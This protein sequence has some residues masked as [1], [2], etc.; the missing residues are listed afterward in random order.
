MK[1]I[2]I[3]DMSLTLGKADILKNITLCMEAGNI[4]GLVGRNGSGKTMLMKCI[5]GFLR[6]TQGRIMIDD[7]Q[8]G[9][10]IDFPPSLGCVIEVPGFIP[11]ESGIKNLLQLAGLRRQIDKAKVEAAMELVGLE[12]KKQLPVGKYSL[13]MRQRLGLAQALMEEPELL[14]LDEPFNSLDEYGLQEMRAVIKNYA[15]N[16]RIVIMASHS[17]EDIGILC[18][19]VFYLRNGRCVSAHVHKS[20]NMK[21]DAQEGLE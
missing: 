6:P 10:E 12:P 18:D 8:L 5:C 15:G 21:E 14:V 17:A 1:T 19:D 7:L 4:Y 9:R 16:E 20:E 11:Y 13:G 3:E 2:T